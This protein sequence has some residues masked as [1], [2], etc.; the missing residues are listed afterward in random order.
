MAKRGR[1]PKRARDDNG[2]FL[3]DDPSTPENEAWVQNKKS[4][5]DIVNEFKGTAK[6]LSF[7]KW[8]TNK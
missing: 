5:M 6:R 3:G 1:P 8:L 2:Q 4:I 7:F